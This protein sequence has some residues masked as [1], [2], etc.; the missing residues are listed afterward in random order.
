VVSGPSGFLENPSEVVLLPNCKTA[1]FF[2]LLEEL[3]IETLDSFP[4]LLK[5][6]QCC[7]W[8]LAFAV[9]ALFF[10]YFTQV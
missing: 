8:Y 9:G 3:I 6:L 5:R 10:V 2:A 4:F 1:S 7:N